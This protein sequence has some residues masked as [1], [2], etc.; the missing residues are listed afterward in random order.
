MTG[1]GG[2]N[3]LRAQIDY[4]SN[5]GTANNGANGVVVK[6]GQNPVRM[7]TISDGTSNTLL[8]AERWRALSWYFQP[9]GPETDDYRGGYTAGYT[10]GS[11]INL[12]GAY[13]PSLDSTYAVVTDLRKFGSAHPSGFHGVLADGT[14]RAIRYDVNLGV[15]TN[16]S[17]RNDGQSISLDDL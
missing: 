4:G 16:L 13:Q 6:M 9:G 2:S 1:Q 14:V 15:F 5:Q 17:V 3:G 10:A 11:G 8:V 12:W 7:A